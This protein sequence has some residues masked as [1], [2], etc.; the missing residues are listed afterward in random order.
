MV[1]TQSIARIFLAFFL[2]ESRKEKEKKRKLKKKLKFFL[3]QELK[4]KKFL[5]KSRVKLEMLNLTIAHGLGYLFFLSIVFNH[6]APVLLS[7]YAK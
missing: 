5:S 4:R 6:L 1:Q 7:A 2:F 3:L